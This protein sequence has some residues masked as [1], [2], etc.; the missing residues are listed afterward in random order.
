MTS[1]RG[2]PEIDVGHAVPVCTK[3]PHRNSSVQITVGM[4]RHYRSKSDYLSSEYDIPVR[5]S[6]RRRGLLRSLIGV[7]PLSTT[8]VGNSRSQ[9]GERRF[10]PERNGFGFRNWR[11]KQREFEPPETEPSAAT[12]REYITSEWPRFAP[13]LLDVDF[14]QVDGALLDILTTLLRSAI[15]QQAGTNG[16]CYGMALAAQAYFEAPE[17]LPLDKESAAA[18]RHPTEPLS[19]PAAPVYH[20]IV[21]LQAEQ[22]LRFRTW[23]GRRALL[24]PERID[25]AAQLDDIRAVIDVFGTAQVS[26]FSSRTNG[27]QVLAYGY[28]KHRNSISL[29]VYDPNYPA[30]TYEHSTQIIEFEETDNGFTMEPYGKYEWILFN[31]YDRIEDATQRT[32]ATPLDHVDLDTAQLKEMIFPTALVTVD[33]TD[34]DLTVADPNGSRLG[35][36]RSEF[37]NRSLGGVSRLRSEYGARAGAY[38]IRLYGHRSTPYELRVRIAGPDGTRLVVSHTGQIEADETQ[39]YTATVPETADRAGSFEP[40]DRG[41]G[42]LPVTV[43]AVGGLT[44]GA[45]AHYL[46][47]KRQRGTSSDDGE[48]SNN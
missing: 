28:E 25:V 16:H 35:R 9:P 27:H 12:I 11:S 31:R 43:A 15:I 1:G 22:F 7:A 39:M 10:S 21:Q 13:D 8:L 19:T 3:P 18:I 47:T 20:E 32:A 37:M 48:Y 23:L 17:T 26:L 2:L 6:V 42:R 30:A 5:Q 33:T 29:Y 45:G 34:V 36:L 46:W 14:G 40:V 4:D 38:R 24:Q 44:A 41:R